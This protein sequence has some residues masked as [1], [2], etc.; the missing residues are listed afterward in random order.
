[1]NRI[2][3]SLDAQN[4]YPKQLGITQ[5]EGKDYKGRQSAA[6]D[7]MNKIV[8]RLQ[9]EIAIYKSS[10]PEAIQKKKILGKCDPLTRQ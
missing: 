7:Y 9:L 3:K 10:T 8:K 2:N 4:F 1:M 5:I 6:F